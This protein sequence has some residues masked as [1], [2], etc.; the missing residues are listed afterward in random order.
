MLLN[1]RYDH[2][3]SSHRNAPVTPKGNANAVSFWD[4]LKW[5]GGLSTEHCHQI[6]ARAANEP[7]EQCQFVK[8]L[9]QLEMLVHVVLISSVEITITPNL[10]V[11]HS[12]LDYH[13]S[14]LSLDIPYQPGVSWIVIVRIIGRSQLMEAVVFHCYNMVWE[15]FCNDIES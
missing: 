14:A 7:V 4:P 10:I 1:R 12:D 2:P 8:A 9:F 3:E 6:R 15:T 5:R 13:I 11:I